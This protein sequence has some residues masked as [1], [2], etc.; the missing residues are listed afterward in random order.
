VNSLP[1]A[2]LPAALAA[3]RNAAADAPQRTALALGLVGGLGEELLAALLAAP[4]YR[5]VHVGVTQA[6]TNA[7]PKFRPWLFG[8]GVVLAYDAFFRPR[9]PTAPKAASRR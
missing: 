2:P 9:Y 8:R 3:D 7:A 1:S 4:E 5:A 6:L